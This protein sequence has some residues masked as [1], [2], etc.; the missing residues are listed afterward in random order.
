MHFPAEKCIFLQKNALSCTK[1]RF[2]GGHMAGNRRKLQEGF[3]A[4][5]SRTLANFHKI[6]EPLMGGPSAFP[7]LNVIA[8]RHL[9]EMRV[10][11]TR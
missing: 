5:E 6:A 8:E 7:E 3:R 10:L 11:K 9:F 1:M 4:Q 2:S